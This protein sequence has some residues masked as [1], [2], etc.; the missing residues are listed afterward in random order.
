MIFRYTNKPYKPFYNKIPLHITLTTKPPLMRFI[1]SLLLAIVLFTLTAKSQTDTTQYNLWAI[2]VS[3]EFSQHITVKGADLQ[4][5]AINNLGEYMKNRTILA[6]GNND[7][8]YYFV[9]GFPHPAAHMINIHDIEELTILFNPV[10]SIDNRRPDKLTVL[11]KTNTPSEKTQVVFNTQVNGLRLDLPSVYGQDKQ[12]GFFQQ[13]YLSVAGTNKKIMYGASFTY[14]PTDYNRKRYQDIDDNKTI[15]R[16]WGEYNF[17]QKNTLAL[18]VTNSSDKSKGFDSL[19]IV[20]QHSIKTNA[21]FFN[22]NYQG[23]FT[24]HLTNNFSAQYTA[25]NQKAN[26][27]GYQ[28]FIIPGYT[29]SNHFIN[30]DT[31]K[32]RI[33]EIVNHLQ[34]NIKLK[35][36]RLQPGLSVLYY[37]QQLNHDDLRT[38]SA[39]EYTPSYPN[40]PNILATSAQAARYDVKTKYFNFIPNIM[41]SLANRVFLQG[42]INIHSTTDFD[43]T[44]SNFFIT[45]SVNLAK[46]LALEKSIDWRIF[47]T[48]GNNNVDELKRELAY[49]NTFFDSLKTKSF[50]TGTTVTLKKTNIIINYAFQQNKLDYTGYFVLPYNP[51]QILPTDKVKHFTH[52]LTIVA[53]SFTYGAFTFNTSIILRSSKRKEAAKEYYP[54]TI[55]YIPANIVQQNGAGLNTR[56][57][58]KKTSLGIDLTHRKTDYTQK[59]STGTDNKNAY[60]E[61]QSSFFIGHTLDIRNKALNL[62]VNMYHDKITYISNTDSKRSIY[63][64]GLRLTL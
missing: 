21:T 3:K 51:T 49:R 57:A 39:I 63:G 48:Y 47:G 37:D 27:L 46:M 60:P 64:G 6:D 38:S 30:S 45:S 26:I 20:Q 40:N 9:N 2:Q 4:K 56:I 24:K 43:H 15:F 59:L 28:A 11:V 35:D 17:N 23:N 31:S 33:L 5:M 44:R 52:L 55:F 53:P 19:Q 12:K 50:Y 22:L 32:S 1:F 36:I 42:G 8:I 58:Y 41:L 13:H 14:A 62:F 16:A 29:R 18:S 25:F 54:N 61:F 7:T 34:Y 10:F